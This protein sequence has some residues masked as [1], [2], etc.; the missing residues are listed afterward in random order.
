MKKIILFLSF[1]LLGG[2]LFA[3]E[4]NPATGGNASGSSGTVS[5]TIGQTF[6]SSISQTGGIVRQ[7]VQ[8][9]YEISIAT[10]VPN[11]EYIQLKCSVYPNPTSDYL[12]LSIETDTF[13]NMK[14]YLYDFV[15]K[16]LLNKMITSDKTEIQMGV[17]PSGTYILKITDNNKDIKTF[18]IIKN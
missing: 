13:K 1:A 6:Y 3:Q 16:P 18:K 4:T 17:Y 10:S 11:T 5:Y 2:I 15:G 14:F 8:L 12:I 7:G 9:P